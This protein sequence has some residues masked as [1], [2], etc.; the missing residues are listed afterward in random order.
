MDA[1][2]FDTRLVDQ[3]I[4][5]ASQEERL[6]IAKKAIEA[7]AYAAAS[8]GDGLDRAEQWS[9]DLHAAADQLERLFPVYVGEHGEEWRTVSVKRTS[10][11]PS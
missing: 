11:A 6:E 1:K 4:Y 2:T 3:I 7:L 9:V 5:R 10:W 8:R